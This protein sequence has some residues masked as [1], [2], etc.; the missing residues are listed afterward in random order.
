[1]FS[2]L[3][4]G[5]KSM[6]NT[7]VLL[8]VCLLLSLCACAEEATYYTLNEDIYYHI[9]ANCGGKKGMVPLSREAADEFQKY[10]CPICGPIK[11][12]ISAKSVVRGGTI[13]SR[14]PQSWLDD[15]KKSA[16]GVFAAP[17]GQT[18]E[19]SEAYALLSEYLHGENYTDFIEEYHTNGSAETTVRVPDILWEKGELIMNQRHFGGAYYIVFRPK[20]AFEDSYATYARFFEHDLSMENGALRDYVEREW[21]DPDFNIVLDRINDAKSVYDGA[22]DGLQISIFCEMDTNIAVITERNADKNRISRVP[23]RIG[24]KDTGIEM[25][26]YMDGVDA[27]YCCVL[28]DGELSLIQSGAEIALSREK[29]SETADFE[30]TDYAVVLSGEYYGIINRNHEFVLDAKYGKIN[31]SSYD[32]I[33]VASEAETY[34]MVVYDAEENRIIA[35][36]DEDD[37]RDSLGWGLWPVVQ[38]KTVFTV[39]IGQYNRIY[40]MKTGELISE[41]GEH[42]SGNLDGAFLGPVY[43]D[44]DCLVSRTEG[45]RLMDYQGNFRSQSYP[46]IMPLIWSGEEG[47][48]L[49][50]N[51]ENEYEIGTDGH[52]NAPEWRCGLIDQNGNVLA[53]MEY[54]GASI[55]SGYKVSLWDDRGNVRDFVIG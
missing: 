35:T 24:D 4:I 26:G 33:F 44:P 53:E 3:Y 52:E 5:V 31:R 50:A 38:N 22:G 37:Y 32:H 42:G 10:L 30:G 34:K 54:V 23:L 48:F 55:V 12:N 14:I 19:G 45:M 20:N 1:M 13:V 17:S 49:A 28:T 9:H 27:V 16:T 6:K 7:L 2:R 39:N 15:P 51:M 11:Q 46:R 40:S 21:N 43:G 47:L 25:S 41:L 18:Y 36:L 8:I 29:L